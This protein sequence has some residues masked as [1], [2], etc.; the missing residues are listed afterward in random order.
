MVDHEELVELGASFGAFDQ[1]GREIYLTQIE[2]IEARWRE[3]LQRRGP[4]LSSASLLASDYLEQT[5]AFLKGV[6]LGSIEEYAAVLKG[7]HDRM[8]RP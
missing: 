3:L 5:D 2:D 6:G 8:R 4:D 1:V 7:A